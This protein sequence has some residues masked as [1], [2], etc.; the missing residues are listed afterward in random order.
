MILNSKQVT[1]KGLSLEN[2]AVEMLWNCILGVNECNKGITRKI[3]NK[4]KDIAGP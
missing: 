4:S 2:H 3:I 1:S